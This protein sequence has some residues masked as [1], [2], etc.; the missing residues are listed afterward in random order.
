MDRTQHLSTEQGSPLSSL[1][2]KLAISDEDIYEAMKEISGY[3]DITASDFKVLYQ[4][5]Y[6]HAM[7]RL[8]KSIR[9]GDIMSRDVIAVTMTTPLHEVAARMA[10]ASLS[11]VPVLDEGQKIMG[12]ISEQDFLKHMGARNGSFMS[13]VADCL[14]GSK[15]CA[16]INVRKGMAADI[17]STPAI[18][19]K[20]DA[21]LAEIATTMSTRGVN[22]LPVVAREHDVVVGI[23]T[24]GDL[25]RTHML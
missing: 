20:E 7:E 5:S 16:A 10:E 22:R 11:G 4:F 8:T 1:P 14:Q 15:G 25:V 3:L 24:R 9:A 2:E 23:V 21:S 17:M 6:R 12:I 13:I 19:I 18:T